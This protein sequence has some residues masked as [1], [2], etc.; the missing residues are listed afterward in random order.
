MLRLA[1]FALASLPIVWVSRPSLLHPASHGFPRFFA[2]E[3]CLA[4]LLL[5]APFWFVDPLAL[6]QLASWS[7]LGASVVLV[8]WGF[9]LLRR[10]GGFEPRDEASPEFGWE[11]TERLVTSGIYRHIRHPMYSSLLFF[12]AGALLKSLT[13][14]TILT[15][16]AAS[17]ALVATAKAEEAENLARFGEEYREYMKQTSRFIPH[18]L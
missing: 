5:N 1:I 11:R 12:T 13:L 7:L 9:L 15:A 3:A 18:V 8:V 4:L 6:R 16:L 10:L 17:V 2:F 14:G